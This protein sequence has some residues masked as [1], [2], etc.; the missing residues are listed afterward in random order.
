MTLTW[1][2]RAHSE[3]GLVRKNNQDSGFVGRRLLLVADGMGGA[4]A[5][6]LASAVAVDSIKEIDNDPQ[7]PD[8]QPDETANASPSNPQSLLNNAI[9]HANRRIAD[10]VSADFTLE[11]MGTTVT[12]ALLERDQLTLAHIGDSRAY[13]WRDRALEQLT[14]DHSWVQSLIDDGKISEAEAAVH[15][16]RSLLLKVLNGHPA[17]EPDVTTLDLQAGDR[18]LFC[19]DGL[20]GFV[21]DDVLAAHL[22]LPDLN[23]VLA[24]MIESAHEAGGMDNITIILVEVGAEDAVGVTG[25]AEDGVVAEGDPGGA[26][27][28]RPQIF[29]AAAER[30]IP[31]L[32][33]MIRNRRSDENDL[34]DET[35]ADEPTDD[36]DR[37]APQP[38]AKRRIIRPLIGVLII[39]LALA[40]GAGAGFAWSRTQYFVGS[41]AGQVAIFR[42]VSG[43]PEVLGL[44]QVFE[45]QPLS[46]SSLPP[47]YQEMVNSAIDVADLGA[48]RKTVE[49]LR[50]AAKACQAKHAGTAAPPATTTPPPTTP[51]ANTPLANTTRPATPQPSTPKPGATVSTPQPGRSSVSPTAAVTSSGVLPRTGGQSC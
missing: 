17:S 20:C 9:L 34:D 8:S 28:G 43:T 12:A 10:L 49:Q 33:T 35:E 38:P 1:T 51:L 3:I 36:E 4:A 7:T 19:S 48:A 16:H 30:D 40:T 25:L 37:Y 45:V 18:L 31:D 21:D 5:G 39:A 27:P 23:A 6:D 46:V 22:S 47:L 11:G 24:A 42:G 50:Q 44:A 26:S 41:D 29:G 32:D 13:L 15:P 14:H 2:F